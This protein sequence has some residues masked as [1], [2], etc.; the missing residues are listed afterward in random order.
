MDASTPAKDLLPREALCFIN[1][2]CK[3][4]KTKKQ[5]F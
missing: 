3:P 1:L 2:G 5:K 4:H